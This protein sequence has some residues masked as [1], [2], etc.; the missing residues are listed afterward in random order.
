M[1]SVPKITIGI[2]VFWAMQVLAQLLFKWGSDTPGRWAWG[3]FG[4]HVFGVSSIAFLML[5]YKTMNPNV[6]LGLCIGGAFLMSQLALAVV[7]RSG[8]APV[9]YM[10][11][12]VMT[13][14]MVMLGLGRSATP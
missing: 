2:L 12:V 5:L 7:Y 9:Q 11:I 3:F 6:A 4:G 8:L 10:G 1:M 13:A 14:G